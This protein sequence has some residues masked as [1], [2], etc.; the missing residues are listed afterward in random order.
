MKK[1]NR[2]KCFL[3]YSS[4]PPNA[5]QI[6]K[7]KAVTHREEISFFGSFDMLGGQKQVCE[8]RQQLLT[9]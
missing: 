8:K 9:L 5:R 7:P 4:L 2:L 6:R 1:K 3:F